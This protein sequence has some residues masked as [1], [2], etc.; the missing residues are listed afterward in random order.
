MPV[1]TT[2]N[3][4]ANSRIRKLERS[5]FYTKGLVY[6]RSGAGKT[7]LLATL[8]NSIMGLTESN[9]AEPTLWQVKK[10]LG[11]IPDIWDINCMDD[12]LELYHFLANGNHNYTGVSLDGFTDINSRLI[13]EIVKEQVVRREGKGSIHDEDVPEQGD[14]YRVDLRFTAAVRAFRD[15]P[16]HFW[17]SAL[18]Q[19]IRE[20]RQTVPSIQPKRIAK[21]IMANFNIVGYLDCDAEES[22]IVRSLI[23]TPT[24]RYFGKNPGG[25]L[26][27]VIRNPRLDQIVPHV[28]TAMSEPSITEDMPK[29]KV[30]EGSV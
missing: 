13:R 16:M 20:D 28:V 22:Q 9:I 2:D 19:D 14:W 23:L 29:R 12:L 3:A 26:P 27:D 8:P 15:L 24:E 1:M 18:E 11:Y 25:V 17:A 10:T 21:N 6:A 5:P 30:K 7:W 4:V